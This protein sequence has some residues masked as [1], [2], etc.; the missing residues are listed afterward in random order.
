MYGR[1]DLRTQHCRT[2]AHQQQRRPMT[3]L[4]VVLSEWAYDLQPT[5]DD[6][7]LARQALARRCR[8]DGCSAASSRQH[9]VRKSAGTACAWIC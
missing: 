8:R 5:A 4:A 1:G 9:S 2:A 3:P 7:A 6:F